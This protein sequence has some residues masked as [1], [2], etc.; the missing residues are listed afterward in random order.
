MSAPS[1]KYEDRVQTIMEHT[2]KPREDII[3]PKAVKAEKE[4][5]LKVKEEK[6]KKYEEEK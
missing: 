1:R 4:A 2:K 5:N 6:Q 3:V